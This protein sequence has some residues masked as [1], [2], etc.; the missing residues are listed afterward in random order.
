[1]RPGL[2]P[3]AAYSP[4][5]TVEWGATPL[6]GLVVN[7]AWTS[8]TDTDANV[9]WARGMWTAVQPFVSRRMYSNVAMAEDLDRARDAYGTNYERLV[10]VKTK[11]D[12]TN[13]FRLNQNVK[14]AA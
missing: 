1:M 11:Y 12:P 14:P 5:F 4:V 2:G 8:A 7:A 6:F 9:A 13:F 3:G 10:E